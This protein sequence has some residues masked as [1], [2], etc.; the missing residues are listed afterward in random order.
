MRLSV[1]PTSKYYAQQLL[2]RAVVYHNGIVITGVVEVC[3]EEGWVIAAIFDDRGM[4][5]PHTKSPVG[6]RC[7]KWV[8]TVQV[9]LRPSHERDNLPDV[10]HKNWLYTP[11]PRNTDAEPD[12][13]T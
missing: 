9:S 3:E 1:I 6:V 2:T 11:S 7:R 12:A 4:T 13:G 5:V 8:G 10:I